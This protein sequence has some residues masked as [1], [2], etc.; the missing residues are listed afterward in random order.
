MPVGEQH[1]VDPG[2]PV[3]RGV[4]RMNTSAPLMTF[5]RVSLTRML[6]VIGAVRDLTGFGV[7]RTSETIRR[8]VFGTWVTGMEL[9]G[10]GVGGAFVRTTAVC[11]EIA[12]AEPASFLADTRTRSVLPTS[13]LRTT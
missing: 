4:D 7:N 2:P 5:P 6:T 12:D 10:G 3:T 13:P 1:L 11:A 9:P 8:A